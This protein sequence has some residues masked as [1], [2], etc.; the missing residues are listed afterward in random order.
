MATLREPSLGPIVGHTTDKTCRIWI[1]GVDPNDR[2]AYQHSKR[3]TVGVIAL[4][5]ANEG[6]N[7]GPV[8]YYFV[9][10]GIKYC[11]QSFTE[12]LM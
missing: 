5:E 11:P 2:G 12:F 8:V 4:M 9:C 7:S 1:R 3:L 10:T 6:G